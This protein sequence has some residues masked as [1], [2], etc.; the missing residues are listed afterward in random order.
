MCQI[1]KNSESS[2][3]TDTKLSIDSTVNTIDCTDP[4]RRDA[5]I[6]VRS[7]SPYKVVSGHF[8][9]HFANKEHFLMRTAFITFQITNNVESHMCRYLQMSHMK[10]CSCDICISAYNRL[11]LLQIGS[12]YT[13]TIYLNKTNAQTKQSI[14]SEIYDYWSKHF[15]TFEP[16]ESSDNFLIGQA[17]MLMWCAH[18][19]WKFV[20]NHQQAKIMLN[21]SVECLRK[22]EKYDRAMEHDL[23]GQIKLLNNEM[24]MTNLHSGGSKIPSL[25]QKKSFIDKES[26]TE[27]PKNQPIAV[28][29]K[30]TNRLFINIFEDTVPEIRPKPVKFQIHDD[31]SPEMVDSKKSTKKKTN[32]PKVASQKVIEDAAKSIVDLTTPPT[33][34]TEISIVESSPEL[35]IKKPTI[36]PCRRPNQRKCGAKSDND[37]EISVQPTKIT[38]RRA[39][40]IEVENTPVSRAMRPRRERK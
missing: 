24:A 20:K 39:N 2:L 5:S 36:K 28:A 38:R 11:V 6:S 29:K 17:R 13:R 35:V 22:V 3:S 4:I 19:Q 34:K 7:L 1:H 9:Y 18:V 23:L 16:N 37:E 14:Q 15:K 31:D 40:E 30:T 25:N 21:E 32:N 8:N 10:N 27:I 33:S 12:L 26:P